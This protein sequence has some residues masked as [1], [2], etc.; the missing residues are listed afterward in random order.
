MVVGEWYRVTTSS[1]IYY[2]IEKIEEPLGELT[3]P[4]NTILYGRV[5]E[6]TEIFTPAGPEPLVHIA[7]HDDVEQD[8]FFDQESISDIT[9]VQE[10]ISLSLPLMEDAQESAARAN[11]DLAQKI[12]DASG[13]TDEV[14]DLYTRSLAQ[15]WYAADRSQQTPYCNPSVVR[16][17]IA[18]GTSLMIAERNVE[19]I[20]VVESLLVQYESDPD[21]PDYVGRQDDL[22]DAGFWTA[23]LAR[24]Y[25]GVKRYEEEAIET[26]SKLLV[27]SK[28]IRNRYAIKVDMLLAAADVFLTTGDIQRAVPLV[29]QANELFQQQLAQFLVFPSF[30]KDGI[31]I[32]ALSKEIK[33]LKRKAEGKHEK[34]NR[35]ILFTVECDTPGELDDV[36]AALQ[37]AL[38]ETILVTRGVE[39]KGRRHTACLEIVI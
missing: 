1:G 22:T 16:S 31:N 34:N 4:P 28:K 17:L 36:I 12:I 15:R 30:R 25:C 20:P 18:L 38:A 9:P 8:W 3:F 13:I 24:L 27:I 26:A 2:C 35:A 7:L 21:Y 39:Q 5:L 37:N 14:I 6:I 23:K 11:D 19:A 32:R 33:R 29:E 10:I